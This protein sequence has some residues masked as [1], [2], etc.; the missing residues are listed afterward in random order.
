MRVFDMHCDTLTRCKG[1]GWQLNGGECDLKVA[2][3]KEFDCYIQLYAVF[4]PDEVRGERAGQFFCAHHAFYRRQIEEQGGTFYPVENARQLHAAKNRKGPSSILAVEGGA[5][6][7]GDLNKIAE[8][9]N[10]GVRALTLTWN[11][12]N[13]I[14]GGVAGDSGLTEFGHAAIEQL[15]KNGIAVDVSHLSDRSFWEVL[16]AAKKPVIATHSN[17][18]AVCLHRRNLTDE[19]FV[20][21]KNRG[22]V[23]GLNFASSF[24][25]DEG[26]NANLAAMVRHVAHFLALGGQDT[27]ALGSDYDGAGIDPCIDRPKKLLDLYEALLQSGI[28]REI[29]DKL[30]FEN[31]YRYFDSL[32]SGTL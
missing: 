22:G 31:A 11:G 25:T 24:I 15:E 8:L 6:L 7:G 10:A 3:M 16:E 13:E 28:S 30:F 32:I 2:D 21:V 23:V 14:A 5:V 9:K 19:Q 1:Q 26:K 20:A 4:V 27:V 18:R 17:A 12:D 29:A